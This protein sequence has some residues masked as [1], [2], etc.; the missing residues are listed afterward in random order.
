M[1]IPI[2]NAMAFTYID[3]M[4]NGNYIFF[5]TDLDIDVNIELNVTHTGSGNF[6]LF[7]FNTRPIQT[8]VNDDKSLNENI[9]TH[10]IANSLEDNPYLNYTAPEEKIYYIEIIL[11]DDGP[12][13][14]YFTS[15][16]S[17]NNGTIIDKDLTQYY[18]PIISSFTFEIIITSVFLSIGIIIFISKKKI[19]NFN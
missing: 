15:T 5:L 3:N 8:Y 14:C 16:I 1:I 7:L 6:T 10:S 4:K 9:F 17:Y 12:D 11:V 13:N 2:N 18:L 19:K